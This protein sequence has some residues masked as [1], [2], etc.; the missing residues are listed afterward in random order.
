MAAQ[1]VATPV[2]Q[3]EQIATIN[4]SNNAFVCTRF[5]I[6]PGQ[7]AL[8]PWVAAMAA[9]YQEYRVRSMRFYLRAAGSEYDTACSRGNITLSF[10]TNAGLPELASEQAATALIPHVV[11]Q[12]S[13]CA[14]MELIVEPSSW[15]FV[16]PNILPVGQDIKT[17]DYG[18]LFVC[19]NGTNNSSLIATL[20]CSYVFEFRKPAILD[21]DNT[22]PVKQPNYTCAQFQDLAPAKVTLATGVYSTLALATTDMNGISAVNVAGTIALHPGNYRIHAAAYF[23][24]NSTGIFAANCVLNIDGVRQ[25]SNFG[26]NSSILNASAARISCTE[27]ADIIV[28]LPS[29]GTVKVEVL[30]TFTA[31]VTVTAA[32]SLLINSC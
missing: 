7:A 29:G 6:N 4:G 8:F 27:A 1:E 2:T 11:Q 32:G 13:K 30:S 25:F 5:A 3:D 24:S 18:A 9:N 12:V 31:G 19:V 20:H 26:G 23:E 17:F 16:R 28:S 10:T 14:S 15:L 22:Q 21:P